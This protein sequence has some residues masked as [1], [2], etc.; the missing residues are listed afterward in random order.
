L[1]LVNK[2]ELLA[3]IDEA[4]SNIAF[5]SPYQS[6]IAEMIS[7][8]ECVRDIVADALAEPHVLSGYCPICKHHI[9]LRLEKEQW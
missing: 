6:N 3:E 4:I 8:M 5:S 1:E 9:A 2:K 7:G